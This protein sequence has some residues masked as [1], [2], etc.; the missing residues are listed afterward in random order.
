MAFVGT[1]IKYGAAAVVGA[2]GATKLADEIP[3]ETKEKVRVAAK[4]VGDD[5]KRFKKKQ[6]DR[7]DAFL[8]DLGKGGPSNG[9]KT[10]D[11]PPAPPTSA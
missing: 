6:R 9:S 11:A 2:I 3:P 5:L 1:V 7:L 4:A 10:G 8:D